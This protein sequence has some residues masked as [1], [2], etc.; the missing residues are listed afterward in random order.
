MK[1]IFKNAVDFL[2]KFVPQKRFLIDL[3]T[4]TQEQFDRA[5][6]NPGVC[7]YSSPCIIGAMLPPTLVARIVTA[8]DDQTGLPYMDD[9]FRFKSREDMDRANR[10]QKLFDRTQVITTHKREAF[11]EF[12]PHLDHS[13]Y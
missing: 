12:L 7:S 6:A 3:D 1:N 5:M 8:G 13:K 10:L 4:L 11:K 2:Q 9:F